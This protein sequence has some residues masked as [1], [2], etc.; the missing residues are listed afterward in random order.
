MKNACIG[1]LNR[2]PMCHGNCEAYHDFLER[3]QK[4]KRQKKRDLIPMDNPYRDYWQRKRAL[5]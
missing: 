3:F 5:S 1:C 4:E 2:T